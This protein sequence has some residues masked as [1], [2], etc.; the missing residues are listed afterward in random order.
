WYSWVQRT[1]RNRRL[2]KGHSASRFPV[3]IQNVTATE[4]ECT[5]VLPILGQL[6]SRNRSAQRKEDSS[7]RKRCGEIFEFAPPS[8]FIDE[9][10]SPIGSNL[11]KDSSINNWGKW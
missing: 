9:L 10:R 5:S 11:P 7:R 4:P 1:I 6:K 2:F 8:I 3:L